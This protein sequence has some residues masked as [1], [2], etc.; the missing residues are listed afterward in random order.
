M[1]TLTLAHV[2]DLHLG[3][4]GADRRTERICEALVEAGVD[5][6]MVT[7][8]ITQKGRRRE[9]ETFLRAFAPLLEAGRV[10]VVPGNHDRAEEDVASMIMPGPRVQPV[11]RE[12]LFVVRIDSTAAHNRSLLTSHGQ[13]G[14]EDI[15]AVERAVD[16]APKGTLVVLALHHHLHPLP[17]DRFRENLISWLGWPWCDELPA[18]QRLLERVKGRCDLVLHGHRHIP[19]ERQSLGNG[20]RAIGIYNA[21]SSPLLEKVR[22]FRH[23]A[24]VLEGAPQWLVTRL[25]PPRPASRPDVAGAAAPA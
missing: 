22:V 14:E 16:E 12:G 2:S 6:V 5:H 25:G 19:S 10:T 17:G 9:W 11:E 1:R 3:L 23:S 8:D 13:V 24:G 15:G 20:T 21:G 4:P 7:G 18:G